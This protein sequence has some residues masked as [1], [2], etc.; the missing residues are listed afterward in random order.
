MSSHPPLR[1]LAVLKKILEKRLGEP[2]PFDEGMWN[3]CNERARGLLESGNFVELRQLYLHMAEFLGKEGKD[4][5]CVLEEAARAQLLKLRQDGVRL[6]AVRC[7]DGCCSHCRAGSGETSTVEEALAAMPLPRP[8]CTR[9]IGP[10][11]TCFYCRCEYE[12][13]P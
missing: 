13:L 3:L 12:A 1:D 2:L 11:R 4:C 7:R 6:V 9:N 10:G 8:A 5:A